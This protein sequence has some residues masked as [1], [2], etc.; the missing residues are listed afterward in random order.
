MARATLKDV[1]A[2]AGVSYQTVSNVVNGQNGMSSATREVVLQAMAALDYQPNH[3]ARAMRMARANTIAYVVYAPTAASF[4]DPYVGRILDGLHRTLRGERYD[5]MTHVLAST[6]PEE[7][8]ALR[9]L[10]RGGRVDGAVL[11]A[12]QVP[13]DLVTALAAWPHPLVTFDLVREGGAPGVTAAHRDGVMGAVAHLAARGRRRIAFVA[14][15]SPS[16]HSVAARRE[17]GYRDGLAAVGLQYDPTLVVEGDWSH[18]SGR[19]ALGTLLTRGERPDAVIA[20]S[21]AMAVGVIGEA[22]S[23][24]MRVPEDLAVVGFDDFDFATWVDPALTTVRLP[25]QAMAEHAAQALL[26]R[27]AGEP[28]PAGD[29]LPVSLV[30]RGSA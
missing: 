25:V 20:A 10:F 19:A 22:R 7:L 11:V 5:L 26:A 15:P 12:G 21:D 3:A 30:V 17:Q 13:D 2:R 16:P 28:T 1:A 14:G 18:A 6:D 4:A 27:I 8:D 29:V 9:A 24:F 23:R